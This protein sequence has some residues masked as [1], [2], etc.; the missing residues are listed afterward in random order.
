MISPQTPNFRGFI[1]TRDTE[2]QDCTFSHASGTL[3]VPLELGST[4]TQFS[5]QKQANLGR[6]FLPPDHQAIGSLVLLQT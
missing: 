3:E 5:G 4:M 1:T 2:T 6:S